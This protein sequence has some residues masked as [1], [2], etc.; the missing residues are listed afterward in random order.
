MNVH[1]R[2]FQV[3]NTYNSLLIVH[4]NQKKKLETKLIAQH[5]ISNITEIY[6]DVLS[7]QQSHRL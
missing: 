2:D 5:K 6:D 1:Q 4:R 7:N 3:V